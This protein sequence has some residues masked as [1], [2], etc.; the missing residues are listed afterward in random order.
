MKNTIFI[1]L[2]SI[3]IL[4]VSAFAQNA[5]YTSSRLDNLSR[6]LKRITVDLV[7]RTEDD[8]KRGFSNNKREIEAAFFAQQFD[9]SAGLFQKM[10]RD[11]R[12]ATELRDASSILKD[13]V[14]RAPNSGSNRNLWRDAERSVDDIERELGGFGG[15]DNGDDGNNNQISGRAYWRGVVDNRVQI[16]INSRRIETKTVAG[17][18]YPEGTYTFT[19][20][21]PRK[22][23]T[24]DF[25]KKEGRGNVR[26]I[27]QPTR[28]NDFTAI[29]EITDNDGGAKEYQLE[30][31]WK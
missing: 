11:N 15:N 1:A 9:A 12:R 6:E 10:V 4:S 13:L 24:V 19:S 29:I 20:P 5:E 28:R 17:R 31:F 26:V 23:V 22:G 8:L 14:R 2:F 27:Q 16:I 21:L 18:T 3:L 25:D 30:I 7:D